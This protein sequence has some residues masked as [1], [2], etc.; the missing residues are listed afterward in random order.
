[1][2]RIYPPAFAYLWP[3][4]GG[5]YLNRIH[6]QEPFE[7]DLSQRNSAYY[8][9]YLETELIGIFRILVDEPN[10]DS[11]ELSAIKL[12]RIYLA[13]RAR[14]QGVGKA[15]I[16]YAKARTVEGGYDQLWLERMD[17]NAATIAFYYRNG[18]VDGS[19]FRLPYEQMHTRFRGMVRMNWRV[20]IPPDSTHGR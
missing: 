7:T 6:G 13:E 15:L 10:P 16:N 17:T 19:A 18:F 9:V 3:D 11:P 5:W 4:G 2:Q 1:M 8:H 14:G 12:D 20:L